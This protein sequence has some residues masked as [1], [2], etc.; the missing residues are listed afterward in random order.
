MAK[1]I[2]SIG[3]KHVNL[4]GLCPL[5]LRIWPH[6]PSSPWSRKFTTSQARL[7]AQEDSQAPSGEPTT[8]KTTDDVKPPGSQGPNARSYKR[9]TSSEVAMISK[10]RSE[11]KTWDEIGESLGRTADAVG[12]MY[13]SRGLRK[14]IKPY[15]EDEIA[16]IRQFGSTLAGRIELQERMPGR[17]LVSITRKYHS[18]LKE[19][20]K[21]SGVK[22]GVKVKYSKSED[23]LIQK[24]R[25]E[26]LEFSEICGELFPR[27]VRAGS[28]R[29]RYYKIV[30]RELRIERKSS[31]FW[32]DAEEEQLAALHS[33]GNY[34]MK[35]I[36][37]KMGKPHSSVS[38][39]LLNQRVRDS[40]MMD[41]A[42]KR[43]SGG[44]RIRP[45]S[46]EDTEKLLELDASGQYSRFDMAMI[47]GRTYG[48]MK[49]KLEYLVARRTRTKKVESDHGRIREP[50]K[51]GR[52]SYKKIGKKVTGKI[53]EDDE[54]EKA[55]KQ[56]D[57][58]EETRKEEK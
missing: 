12:K 20:E 24:L 36:A 17:G 5:E 26:G 50:K 33:S 54:A 10:M 11:N 19:E 30:P 7:S 23:D 14:S 47:L 22:P 34:T 49:S 25:G 31:V 13:A 52:R 3:S 16:Q 40:Q 57:K 4:W 53:E 43:P 37:L 29:T 41:A 42:S 27:R 15:T 35:E 46:E 2:S 21:H 28:V 56:K 39:Q 32:S 9:Y 8:S 58:Y 38:F 18:L 45:W 55:E 44:S 1:R 51:R 48:A 6:S